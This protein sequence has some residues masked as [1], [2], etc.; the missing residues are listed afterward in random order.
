MS[1]WPFSVLLRWL[2]CHT[3][4]TGSALILESGMQDV[5]WH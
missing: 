1:R 3:Q 5:T 4:N 2:V